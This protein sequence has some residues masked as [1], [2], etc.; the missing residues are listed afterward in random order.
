MVKKI[1]ILIVEMLLIAL[2]IWVISAIL[3]SA[4]A[5][6]LE[7]AWVIC[8]PNDYV[9]VRMNPSRKS[10]VVGFADA[11]DSFLTDGKAKNGY[12]RCYGIGEAGEGWIHAGYVIHDRPER[13]TVS[14][15]VVS[16]GRLAAR[17]HVGGKVRKWLR[18][19]DTVKVYWVSDEWAVTDKGFVKS[20]FIEMEGE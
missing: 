10:Q 8:Q 1:L 5:D 9:N 16:N 14:A 19:M 11:G 15:V 12:V 18:N 2:V 6:E 4:R 3:D 13:V 20:R 7:S 17:Q